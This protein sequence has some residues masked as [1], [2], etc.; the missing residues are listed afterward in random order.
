MECSTSRT[1]FT[2]NCAGSKNHGKGVTY[3]P[4]VRHIEQGTVR[5]EWPSTRT[6][7]PA[8]CDSSG[9]RFRRETT[10]LAKRFSLP[11][12]HGFHERIIIHA[13]GFYTL[14]LSAEEGD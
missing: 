10:H 2:R 11:L 5:Q 4:S 14:T 9:G 13:S 7:H 3:S 12:H 6:P 8:K 1:S